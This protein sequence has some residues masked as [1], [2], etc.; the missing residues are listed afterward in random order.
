M[1]PLNQNKMTALILGLQSGDTLGVLAYGALIG[2]IIA[3]GFV[4]CAT[5]SFRK[6]IVYKG[7]NKS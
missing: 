2:A 7:G 3:L 5:L 4:L 6:K 1:K